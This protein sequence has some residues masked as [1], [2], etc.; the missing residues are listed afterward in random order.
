MSPKCITQ[1]KSDLDIKYKCA[2]RIISCRKKP[3]NK[4]RLLVSQSSQMRY[5]KYSDSITIY[6]KTYYNSSY[7]MRRLFHHFTTSH[8]T[9][10]LYLQ[11]HLEWYRVQALRLDTEWQYNITDSN[12]Y[13]FLVINQCYFFV[14]LNIDNK[15]HHTRE[16]RRVSLHFQKNF[17]V[18]NLT[19][20]YL[21]MME[22]IYDSSSLAVTVQTECPQVN[23]IYAI[24]DYPT[25]VF[26]RANARLCLT[27]IPLKCLWS[28]HVESCTQRMF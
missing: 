23:N 15:E 4:L 5:N 14:K 1:L 16:R 7:T 12:N 11:D 9:S 25:V 20:S 17:T 24:K 27:R 22:G 3:I 19:R 8:F 18:Q 21:G 28:L 2:I 13:T 26:E 6:A 10:V